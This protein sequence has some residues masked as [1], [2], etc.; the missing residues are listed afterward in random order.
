MSDA[1]LQLLLDRAAISDVVHA[2][3]TGLDRRDWALY[4]SIFTDSIEME[5]SSVGLRAGVYSA[6]EWVRSA[7]TLFAGFSATQHTSSN[8]VHAIAGDAATCTSNMQ[9]EHFVA[10][11]P[12]DGLDGPDADR[13]TIGG[14]YRNELQRTRD[15]WKLHRI[16]L[17]VTWSRGN[18]ELSRIALRRGRALRARAPA[19]P[20]P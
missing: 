12:N 5:F 20:R 1:Q 8:H 11:E 14:Y 6:D 2:Y 9:A 18:P 19:T 13:W 4:R 7:Q 10:R 15:G 16:A 17:I 3:A